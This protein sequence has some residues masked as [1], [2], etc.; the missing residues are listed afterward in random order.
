MKLKY[1]FF[2]NLGEEILEIALGISIAK[3]WRSYI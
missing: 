3:Q 1:F 2:Q